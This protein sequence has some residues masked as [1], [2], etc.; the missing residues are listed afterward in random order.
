MTLE[1]AEVRGQ[2]NRML[3]CADPARNAQKE[4]RTLEG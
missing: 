4:E 1:K 2:A 3:K